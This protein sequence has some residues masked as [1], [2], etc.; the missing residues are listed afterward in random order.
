MEKKRSIGVFIFGLFFIIFGLIGLFSVSN[1][2]QQYIH[3]CGII[4]FI[5]GAVSVGASFVCGIFILKL[6]PVARK[7][8]IIICLVDISLGISL[9]ASLINSPVLNRPISKHTKDY[10]KSRQNIILQFKPEYQQKALERL[11]K[12]EEFG[13]KAA[14]ITFKVLLLLFFWIPFFACNLIPIYFFTRPKVKEQFK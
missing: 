13:R 3:E 4:Y 1:N 14:P 10:E 6:N 5:I 8:A 2:S 12:S 11:E 9:Y 7:V